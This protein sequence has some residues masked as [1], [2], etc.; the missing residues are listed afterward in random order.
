MRKEEIIILGREDLTEDNKGK[1]FYDIGVWDFGYYN[2]HFDL[3]SIVMFIDVNGNCR[4]FENIHSDNGIVVSPMMRHKDIINISRSLLKEIVVQLTEEQQNIF[5]RMYSS[6]DME[7][8]IKD[9]VDK[10]TD[11]QLNRAISQFQ[12]TILKRDDKR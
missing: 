5:R 1:C 7:I 10:I 2:S 9:V 3:L 12:N 6:D 8:L 11:E 4:I